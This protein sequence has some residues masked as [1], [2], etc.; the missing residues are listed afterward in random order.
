MISHP[1]ENELFMRSEV[2]ASLIFGAEHA[3]DLARDS[4]TPLRFAQNDKKS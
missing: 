4:S 2:E 1:K 3:M